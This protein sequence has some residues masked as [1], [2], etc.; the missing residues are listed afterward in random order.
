MVNITTN[1]IDEPVIAR[2]FEKVSICLQNGKTIVAKL[3]I[4]GYKNLNDFLTHDEFGILNLID[5][6]YAGRNISNLSIDHSKWIWVKS[7]IPKTKKKI[8]KHY[9][10][11]GE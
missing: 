5:I 1:T 3:D 4:T 7:H 9:A 8:G 11:K 10:V 6:E 2:K